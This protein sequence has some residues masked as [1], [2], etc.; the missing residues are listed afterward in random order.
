MFGAPSGIS[1]QTNDGTKQLSEAEVVSIAVEQNPSLRTSLLQLESAR[2]EV[3]GQQAEY[4]P[5]LAVDGSI[6]Q[7]QQPQLFNTSR[8]RVA[9]LGA[10]V[11][12]KLIWG[13][14]FIF[15]LSGQYQTIRFQQTG[16]N[17][18][19]PGNPTTRAGTFGPGYLL[20][21]KFEIKQPL[22]RGRGREFGEAGIL[23]A[24]EQRTEAERKRDRVASEVL[25]DGLR[26]YW[27]L[28]YTD[29]ALAIQRESRDFT[30]RQRDD[31]R[32]RVETGGLA[33]VDVLSF[34]TTVAER[35][36]AILDAE[37]ARRQ[38][39]FELFRQLGVDERP[40]SLSVLEDGVPLSSVPVRTD[41]ERR[42]LEESPQ[43]KELQAAAARARLQNKT[44]ADPE[45]ARLD[46]NAYVQSQGLGN[47]DV[48]DAVEQFGKFEAVSAFGGL[49]Y[50]GPLN[51]NAYRSAAAKARIG[52]E[53]A[54][55]NL[56]QARQQVLSEVGQALD[57]EE[58]GERKLAL[59]EQTR[60]IAKKQLEAEQARF[61]TGTKTSLEVLAAEEK[62]RAAELRVARA[63]ADLV[64]NALTRQHLTGDLLQRYAS[65]AH[66]R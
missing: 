37:L 48:G 2:W 36:E 32:A 64:Q 54:E 11:S 16:P 51:G 34:D 29:R 58:A 17:M 1:A 47:E 20:G 9:N 40:A 18:M 12:K 4:A 8:S 30:A 57:K 25:R 27:E 60:D 31:A 43:L 46:L 42:A 56:R 23:N 53:V 33:P 65:V 62:V 66:T 49:T 59:A 38:R 63:Q 19:I 24:R 5:M 44:A 15:R 3:M 21:A 7:L 22:L 52:V 41:A 55:Q 13:T 61:A 28:W 6:Q 50:E 26:A 10:Q 14:E 39:E 45:R 35:E